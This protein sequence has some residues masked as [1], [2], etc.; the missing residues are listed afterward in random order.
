[1]ERW[2][3]GE[4]RDTVQ[5]AMHRG[6]ERGFPSDS[7]RGGGGAD[8]AAICKQLER[9]AECAGA[10]G[11]QRRAGVGLG[12][13][14]HLDDRERGAHG[15]IGRAGEREWTSSGLRRR[16]LGRQRAGRH[17]PNRLFCRRAPR[18]RRSVLPRQ[19]QPFQPKDLAPG[20]RRRVG[21]W[22]RRQCGQAE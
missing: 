12:R 2:G 19:L 10:C 9:C 6:P 1:M 3:S 14:R 18:L 22:D 13:S 7:E 11:R 5:R 15:C 16:R 20:R 17:R 21:G 8:S 4:H